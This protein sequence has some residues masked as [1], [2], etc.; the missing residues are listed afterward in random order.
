VLLLIRFTVT[1]SD[2]ADLVQVP[3][4]P[5]NVVEARL[6]QYGVNQEETIRPLNRIHR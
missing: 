6:V 5:L 3:P 2:V 4:E 1:G